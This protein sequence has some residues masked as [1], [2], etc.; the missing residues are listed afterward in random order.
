MS[1]TT[2]SHHQSK[3]K[4][5]CGSVFLISNDSPTLFCANIFT[6]KQASCSD[7]KCSMR[8]TRV[9]PIFI[10]SNL[11]IAPKS[12]IQTIDQRTKQGRHCWLCCWSTVPLQVE[13][14][15]QWLEPIHLMLR[16]SR[17]TRISNDEYCSGDQRHT[18]H[19]WEGTMLMLGSWGVGFCHDYG[20]G[21]DFNVD[22]RR[23]T[24]VFHA[25]TK[26]ECLDKGECLQLL[27]AK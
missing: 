8:L 27:W 15:M 17:L 19:V 21:I 11:L 18:R 12:Q 20:K 13:Q 9:I 5:P 14:W 1:T 7:V 10:V 24:T 23:H 6:V 16:E 3:E 22:L 2:H 4:R 25:H 26:H